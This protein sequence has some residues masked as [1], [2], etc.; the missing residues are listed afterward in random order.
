MKLMNEE[1]FAR[2]EE[3]LAWLEMHVSEQDKIMLLQGDELIRAWREI[4][5]LRE[6]FW[7]REDPLDPNERPPH[8]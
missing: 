3:R 7:G 2:L 5:T 6:R 4:M 8:Y 1:R